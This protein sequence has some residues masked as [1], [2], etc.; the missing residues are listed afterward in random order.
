MKKHHLGYLKVDIIFHHYT[1]A[2]NCFDEIP[3]F[4]QDTSFY[5]DHISQQTYFLS[6]KFL[7]M[8]TQLT[9]T[10]QSP[11]VKNYYLQTPA[12]IKQNHSAP[13]KASEIRS[14]I[15]PKT[16]SAHTASLLH[17]NRIKL[18]GIKFY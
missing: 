2:K 5:V 10:L 14:T 3:I 17:L 11:M 4:Y 15:Q 13:L 12:P 7:V 18:S 8:V 6:A 16:F 1:L 9:L